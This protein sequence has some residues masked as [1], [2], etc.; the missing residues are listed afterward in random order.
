[1]KMKTFISDLPQT[2]FLWSVFD[3]IY[4]SIEFCFEVNSLIVSITNIIN[5]NS[6]SWIQCSHYQ[7]LTQNKKIL[8]FFWPIF[9]VNSNFFLT[10]SAISGKNSNYTFTASLGQNQEFFRWGLMSD[11]PII[12]L[13]KLFVY[14][15]VASTYK[16]CWILIIDPVKP[17]TLF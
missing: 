16:S 9:G 8:T 7:I 4:E 10:F 5:I 14:T 3:I 2:I 1:M 13:Y 15:L 6:P 12:T 17:I 11:P